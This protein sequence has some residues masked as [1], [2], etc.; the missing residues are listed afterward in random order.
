MIYKSP[1]TGKSPNIH[2]NCFIAENATI[3]GDVE[4]KEGANIWFGAVIRADLGKIV[5]GKNTSIQEHCTLHIETG[6]DCIIGD[7]CIVGHGAIVHGPCSVGVNTLI[8]I[9]STVLQGSKVGKGCVLAS[10][11]VLRGEM[12]DYT[13]F[14]G[15]PA[16]LKKQL[17]EKVEA[18]NIEAAR[19]YVE[20]GM[21]FEE[22][23]LGL[24][25]LQI[26]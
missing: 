7:N 19:L 10:G 4:I 12:P 11:A 14:A 23:G 25:K 22:A 15:V 20:N 6:T 17:N 18:E 9:S 16:A 1:R 3:I 2:S 21:A 5:V 24:N 13:M 8:G 26:K